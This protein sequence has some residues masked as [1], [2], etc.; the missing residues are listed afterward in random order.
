MADGDEQVELI[1]T[2]AKVK[3]TLKGVVNVDEVAGTPTPTD[4]KFKRVVPFKG[5][6]LVNVPK[7]FSLFVNP[8]FDGAGYP[9][10]GQFST[11][12]YTAT[13]LA[14]TNG[15]SKAQMLANSEAH[16][17][18]P[19]VQPGQP[20]TLYDYVTSYYVPEYLRRVDSNDPARPGF[21]PGST[22]FYLTDGGNNDYYKFSIW[23]SAFTE[24]QQEV[25]NGVYYTLPNAANYSKFSTV[26]NNVYNIE[27]EEGFQLTLNYNIEDW[28]TGRIG[29]VYAGYRF[30]VV[31]EEPTFPG[32]ESTVRI[33]TAE[34]NLVQLGLVEL[35]PLVPNA[36]FT[37]GGAQQN[38]LRFGNAAGQS[39]FQEQVEGTL[40]LPA[41]PTAGTP[42]FQ[43][44]YNNKIVHT[45]KSE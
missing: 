41:E 8:Y 12:F 16:Y 3:L 45:V 21:V 17:L 29:R 18:A 36:K 37:V 7:Y 27:A 5:M 24:G 28:C 22:S 4:I 15:F 25:D 20:T 40:R 39:G 31:V 2:L 42:I 44:K 43:I 30:N 1:R 38:T 6:T 11:D 14:E 19:S 32:G 33:V 10:T 26:R 13:E 35:V 34:K 9:S 23:Q